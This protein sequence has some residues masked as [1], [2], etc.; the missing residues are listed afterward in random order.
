MREILDCNA[1]GIIAQDTELKTV[2]QKIGNKPD[3]IITDSQVV[4]KV[5]QEIPSDINL[6]TFSILFARLKGDLK[7]MVVGAN[8]IDSLNN[9]DKILISEACSHH[10][11]CDDIGRVK[12]PN[13]LKKYTGKELQFEFCSGHDF[14]DD[15]EKF[16]LIIHCGACMINQIEMKRRLKES[17]LLGVPITNYGVVISKIQNVLER[18]IKP[19]F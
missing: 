4:Q 18:V 11:Q 15:L 2:L 8:R 19:L 6:T 12:I 7:A 14:P 17:A 16:S 3:L 10:T 1:I 13:L 9:G 5:V